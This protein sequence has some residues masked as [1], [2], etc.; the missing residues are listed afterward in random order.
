MRLKIHYLSPTFN[1]PKEC[2]GCLFHFNKVSY[3]EIWTSWTYKLLIKDLA[4]Y[5]ALADS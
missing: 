1:M 2:Q 3:N 5:I 4:E